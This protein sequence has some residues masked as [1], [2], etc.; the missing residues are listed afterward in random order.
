MIPRCCDIYIY[1]LARL[2]VVHAGYWWTIRLGFP[3]RITSSLFYQL[4][5]IDICFI[6]ISC[7][8]FFGWRGFLAC[9]EPMC[10]HTLSGVRVCSSNSGL[11]FTWSRLFAQTCHR[12]R[13]RMKSIFIEPSVIC[14]PPLILRHGVVTCH[15]SSGLF[16]LFY[17]IM[18][19]AEW[20]IFFL[21]FSYVFSCF[22]S[23]VS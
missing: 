19:S 8:L 12:E 11:C 4:D 7:K 23:S 9:S 16:F 3:L 21:S 14:L 6:P 17:F 5:L 20:N 1:I 13:E 2:L 10:W 18:Q 15:K 22:L